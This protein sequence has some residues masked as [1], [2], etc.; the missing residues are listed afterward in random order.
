MM[1]YLSIFL[2]CCSAFGATYYVDPVNGN[3]SNDGLSTNLAWQSID[4]G[5]RGYGFYLSPG[6]TLYLRGGNYR[7]NTN[8]IDT[9]ALG[10][11]GTDSQPITIAAYPGETPVV[12]DST[13]PY[14]GINLDDKGWWIFDGITYSNHYKWC[15]WVNV[16]NSII[17]NCRFTTMPAT[18]DYAG[19]NWQGVSQFNVISNCWIGEWEA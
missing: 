19:M 7:G 17:K 2:F 3:N 8:A 6:D 11:S 18:A 10:N 16:T 1:R 12:S 13:S 9:G 5:T 4:R 14:S 15:S